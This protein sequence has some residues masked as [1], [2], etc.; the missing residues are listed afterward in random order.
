M[1]A[2]VELSE[3]LGRSSE[4]GARR[5]VKFPQHE[6]GGFM[7]GLRFPQFVVVV[8]VI[9]S[10]VGLLMLQQIGLAVL[11]SLVAVPVGVVGAIT[12]KGRPL[13]YRIWSAAKWRTRLALGETRWRTTE[14]PVAAGSLMLPG[15][16]GMRVSVH[17]T[18]WGGG[19]STTREHSGRPLWSSVS[20][21]AGT[22]PRTSTGR[23]G[24]AGSRSSAR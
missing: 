16:V 20:R 3:S 17:A 15:D 14:A 11:W 12:W 2:V 22:W 4:A 13:M 10:I 19:S 6:R 18:K 7:W 21:R 1:N 9:I 24:L 23:S 5:R 8:L